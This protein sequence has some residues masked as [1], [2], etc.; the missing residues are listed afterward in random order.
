MKQLLLSALLIIP[1]LSLTACDEEEKQAEPQIKAV[2]T[3]VV[4]GVNGVNMRT[5]SGVV[6]TADESDLSFRVSGRVTKVNVE[7][8]DS[9][10]QGDVLAK[11][12][13]KDYTLAVNAAKAKLQSARSEL[14]KAKQENTRQQNLLKQGFVSKAAAEKAAAAF[15]GAQS[16]VA[17]V[18]TD[19][20]TAEDNLERTILTSPFDGKIAAKEIEAF[21]EV[22]AG[23][24]IFVLQGS[25]GLEVET[26]VPETMVGKLK[27]GSAAQVSFPTLE[28]AEV[29]AMITQIGARSESGNAFPMTLRLNPTEADIRP[30]ITAEVKVGITR[31][32]TPNGD[33]VLIPTSAVDLRFFET[34]GASEAK[35]FV[36]DNETNTLKLVTVT[37]EDVRENELEVGEGLNAGDRLVVAGVAFLNEGQQV[38]LWEPQYSIPATLGK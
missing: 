29:A 31:G 33:R 3:M 20:Q 13:Q 21:R 26:R 2:K 8:G 4:G 34:I 14:T 35:V 15:A 16:K 30:G 7:R 11:L 19:V 38:K 28:G 10:K 12:E 1:L 17:L 27:Q 37:V 18:K 32:D 22:A 25:D 23:E 6:Q 5:L 9:V 24:T 36:V